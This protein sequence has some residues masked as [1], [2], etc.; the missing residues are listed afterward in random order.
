ME[1]NAIQ[2]K[3]DEA[4]QG[5]GVDRVDFGI[6]P[7]REQM[8]VYNAVR[9][10]IKQKLTRFYTFDTGRGERVLKLI[11]DKVKKELWPIGIPL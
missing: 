3:I 2:K 4:L 8:R 1:P 5:Y 9:F 7:A 11:D 6:L 10:E